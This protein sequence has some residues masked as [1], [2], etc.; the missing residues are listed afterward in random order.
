LL[1]RRGVL[2]QFLPGA[3]VTVV[4]AASD[5]E[6]LLGAENLVVGNGV[7]VPIEL[8]THRTSELPE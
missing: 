8:G 5:R 7:E 2:D 1:N 4:R 3:L 6:L